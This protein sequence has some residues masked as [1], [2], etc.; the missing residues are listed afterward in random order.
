[1]TLLI[2]VKCQH[3]DKLEVG[4]VWLVWLLHARKFSRIIHGKLII[5]WN[6]T[7]SFKLFYLFTSYKKT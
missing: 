5:K 6:E 4:S 7:F 1:M 2:D 3:H